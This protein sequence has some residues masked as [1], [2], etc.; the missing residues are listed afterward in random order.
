MKTEL[1]K[2]QW[3]KSYGQI[4]IYTENRI[5]FLCCMAQYF[6]ELE[7]PLRMLGFFFVAHH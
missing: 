3:L 7:G 1:K 5:N 4:K 6:N 2:L